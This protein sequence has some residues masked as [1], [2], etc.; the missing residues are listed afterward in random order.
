MPLPF[1]TIIND[2]GEF[3][4]YVLAPDNGPG[5]SI[6]EDGWLSWSLSHSDLVPEG[7]TAPIRI[8]EASIAVQGYHEFN[9]GA[10]SVTVAR[11]GSKWKM[12]AEVHDGNANGCDYRQHNPGILL[13]DHEVLCIQGAWI[14]T[15]PGPSWRWGA[16]SQQR[17]IAVA[18]QYRIEP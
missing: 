10:F 7:V 14:A 13:T 2:N 4:L 8:S 17:V 12:L 9:K 1:H 6:A 16:S 18:A 3:S 5:F 15:P 11:Y